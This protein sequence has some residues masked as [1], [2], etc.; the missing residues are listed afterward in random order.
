MHQKSIDWTPLAGCLLRV[1]FLCLFTHPLPARS[2]PQGTAITLEAALTRALAENNLVRAGAFALNKAGWNKKQAWSRLFPTL[3]LNTRF[4]RIDERTLAERDFTQFFPPELGGQVPKTVFRNAFYTSLDLSMPLFNG[5]LLNGLAIASANQ[6]AAAAQHQST[7]DRI[8]FTVV[9][10]YLDN[11]KAQDL[12]SVQEEY[13]NLSRRNFEKAGR[14]HKAGRLSKTD[15]LRWK[16]DLQQQKSTVV[17]GRSALRSARTLLARLLNLPMHDPVAVDARIPQ[18]LQVESDRLAA[19]SDAELLNRIPPNDNALI[20]ANPALRAGKAGH[21]ISRLLY[22]NTRAAY[23]PDLSLTYSHA[24]RENNTLALD[25]YSPKIL[26]LHFSM[27]LFTGFQN[28]TALKSAYYDYRQTEEQFADQ[29]Q[30]IRFVLT[31]TANRLINLKTQR[32]LADAN[33]EFNTHSYRIVEQQREKGLVSNLDW[34]DAKLNLQNARLGAIT[35]RYD[36]MAAT[37]E[38]HHLLGTLDT[39]LE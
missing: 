1:F 32:E 11:L 3:R 14:L 16:V 30:N 19:L 31:E 28:F 39:L 7:R 9:R 34:I 27:P 29:I 21:R 38:W 10:T 20:Q 37:V 36:F 12:L 17:A 6:S 5:V 35:A 2:E 26:M 18:R 22:R 23:L 25:D 24:W 8:A 15:V 4:T 33:V 13:L